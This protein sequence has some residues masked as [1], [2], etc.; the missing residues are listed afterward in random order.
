MQ[1]PQLNVIPG[2]NAVKTASGKDV[3]VFIDYVR[4][5]GI[6]KALTAVLKET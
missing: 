4:E 1:I 3:S 2:S 6:T 5:F